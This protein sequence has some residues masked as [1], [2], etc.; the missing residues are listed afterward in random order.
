MV[1]GTRVLSIDDASIV[2]A[3]EETECTSPSQ[4][5]EVFTL[6]GDAGYYVADKGVVTGHDRRGGVGRSGRVAI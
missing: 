2:D 3:P 4:T 5:R 6:F 1:I